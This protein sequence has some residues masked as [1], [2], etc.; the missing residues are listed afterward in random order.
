M[1]NVDRPGNDP[2]LR[3]KLD[4]TA[5]GWRRLMALA[6]RSVLLTASV[7]AISWACIYPA[8]AQADF[9]ERDHWPQSAATHIARDSWGPK[10]ASYPVP[11]IPA[12]CDAAQWQRERVVAVAMKYIGL[13]YRHHHVPGFDG[14]DGPGL[15]CSNFTSW[16]YNYGLGVRL[17]SDIGRQAQTAGRRLAADEPLQAGD[18]L[19]I[20]TLDDRRVSHVAIYLDAHHLIDDHNSG[21]AMREFSGWYASHLAYARRVIE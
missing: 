16:V 14:G 2:K 4:K 17:D 3:T 18:L 7:P 19:F 8:A 5:R 21:V 6:V 11:V 20:K 9:A 13:P 1:M 15:D 10:P 12:G